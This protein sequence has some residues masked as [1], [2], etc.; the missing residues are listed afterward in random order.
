LALDLAVMTDSFVIH[1]EQQSI[2]SLQELLV[3]HLRTV[4]ILV[5][6]EGLVVAATRSTSQWLG[7]GPLLHRP[8]QEVLPPGLLAAANLDVLVADALAEGSPRSLLRVDVRDPDAGVRSYR[9]D[10]LPLAHPL[11]TLILELEELTEVVALEGRLARSEALAQL[12][13]L[14]AA[15]AHELRNPLAGISGAIQVI[16][17]TLPKD[18]PYAPI[19]VKVERE[20]RRL[21]SLVTDLLAFAR[22][23]AVRLRAVNLREP[24][25]SA[26]DWMGDEHPELLVDVSGEGV[27]LADPDLVQQI[28][29]NLLQNAMQ[30]MALAGVASPRVRVVLAGGTVEV[31]DRGPGVPPELGE[32]IFEPFTTTKARGTGLGLAICARSAAAMGGTLRWVHR[33]EPGATFAL[34][35]QPG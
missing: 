32:R 2:E 5:D 13:A 21:D 17:R 31:S 28:L 11:A 3:T 29:L 1:R 6:A 15:V 9:I 4:V 25:Q 33:T 27:A 19:M 14:S 7:G 35:L 24:V 26:V 20:I 12:G 22:P 23:G 34:A 8:W 18:A 16:S 10:L 30:A